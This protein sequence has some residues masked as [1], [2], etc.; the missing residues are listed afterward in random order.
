MASAAGVYAALLSVLLA[1][2]TVVRPLP[3]D[4]LPGI[5]AGEFEEFR[6][7]LDDFT[8]VETVEDGLGPAFNGSSCAVCHSVPAI[9]GAGVVAEVRAARRDEHGEFVELVPSPPDHALPDLSRSRRTLPADHPSRGE[10]DRAA[11]AD[12]AVWRRPGQ[13]I[14]DEA[15]LALDD[16]GDRDRDGI[17]GRAAIVTDIATGSAA[18]DASGGSRSRHAPGVCR[19]CLSATRW[20]SRTIC[21]RTSSRSGSRRIR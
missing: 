13:A 9:G 8:E 19:R 18:S 3:G 4:P 17:S 5:T 6:L 2:Q 20:G 16:G 15:L 12:S 1:G 10:R 7:G 14:P 21:F 11:R